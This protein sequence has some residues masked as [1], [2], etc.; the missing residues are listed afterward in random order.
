MLQARVQVAINLWGGGGLILLGPVHRVTTSLTG[1]FRA[2]VGAITRYVT[3]P[4]GKASFQRQKRIFPFSG[5]RETLPFWFFGWSG[6][7]VLYPWGSQLGCELGRCQPLL[8]GGGTSA[9]VSPTWDSNIV[10][11]VGSAFQA[12]QTKQKTARREK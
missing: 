10:I 5:P 11:P 12:H 3:I 1:I 8:I 7:P 4:P 9:H 6:P 2:W